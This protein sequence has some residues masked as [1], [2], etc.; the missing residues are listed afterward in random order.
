MAIINGAYALKRGI[1]KYTLYTLILVFCILSLIP[2]YFVI[3]TSFKTRVQSFSVP[4]TLLFIPTLENYRYVMLSQNFLKYLANSLVIGLSSTLIS[5]LTGALA[6]YGLAKFDFKGRRVIEKGTLF[7]RMIPPVIIT[8]PTFILW[9]KMRI[10]NLRLGLIIAY[11]AL[12]LPFCIWV[13]RTFILSV[14]SEIDEA[15]TIDGC[16]DLQIFTWIT[17]PLIMPGLSVAGIFTF[18]TSWNE[19]LLSLVLT[20][21]NT[22]TLPVAISL[23]ITEYGIEWGRLTAIGTLIALPALIFTFVAAKQLIM[24]L[25]AGAVKG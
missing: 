8:I 23:Y 15:A 25:T 3:S 11:I 24:G 13:L 22:R 16:S 6:A 17:M 20:N 21:R 9:S 4:P 5:V 10:I 7:L 2:I 12:S 18:R 14:A 19:F 1:T